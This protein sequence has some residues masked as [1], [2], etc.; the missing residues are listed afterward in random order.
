MTVTK[1]CLVASKLAAGSHFYGISES[2]LL[3]TSP[4]S[5]SLDVLVKRAYFWLSVKVY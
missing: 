2:R 3:L 5:E 4:A 1:R